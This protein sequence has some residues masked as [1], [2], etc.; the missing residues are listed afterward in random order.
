MSEP[1]YDLL[2]QGECLPGA[3]PQQVQRDLGQLL[4]L[5]AERLQQMFSGRT[6]VVRR[7]VDRDSAARFQQAFNNPLRILSRLNGSRTPSFFT[8]FTTGSSRRS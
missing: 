7:A 1:F 6:V 4:K 5:D 2:F 3:D 8:T